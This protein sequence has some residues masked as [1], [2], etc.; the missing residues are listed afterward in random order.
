MEDK[1]E[2][3]RLRKRRVEKVNSIKETFF[4]MFTSQS[5]TNDV[6]TET[7]VKI[8]VN[9]FVLLLMFDVNVTPV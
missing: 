9:S 6:S 4:K 7:N 3:Y 2:S 8:E 1:L 5:K